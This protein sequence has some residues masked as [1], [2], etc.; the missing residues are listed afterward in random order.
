MTDNEDHDMHYRDTHEDH[1]GHSSTD[2]IQQR[3]NVNEPHNATFTK[4]QTCRF[5]KGSGASP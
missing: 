5:G 1:G 4:R 3:P 2:L